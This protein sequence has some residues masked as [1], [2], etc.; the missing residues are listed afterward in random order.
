MDCFAFP[1]VFRSLTEFP[2]LGGGLESPQLSFYPSSGQHVARDV[3]D[4]WFHAWRACGEK[5]HRVT[6]IG[7]SS[8]YRSGL[9]PPSPRH[10]H[11][12]PESQGGFRNSAA[13]EILE[14]C[15]GQKGVQ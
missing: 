14:Y 13:S 11:P 6:W 2:P 1:Q 15:P 3:N 7:R 5:A 4:L 10:L 8:R 12:D 9:R